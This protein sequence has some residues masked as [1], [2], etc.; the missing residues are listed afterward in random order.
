MFPYFGVFTHER[1]KNPSRD[2]LKEFFASGEIDIAH[3]VATCRR[4][5]GAFEPKSALEFGCGVGRLLI[6]LAKLTG[7]A[8]GVDVADGMLSLARSYADDAGASV[9]LAKTIPADE[10][11]DLVLS[12]ITLQ[13]IPPGRGYSLIAQLW[14]AVAPGGL[15]VL[16]VTAFRTRFNDLLIGS[17]LL[18]YDGTRAESYEETGDETPRILM[19]DYELSRVFACMPMA[20]GCP[21]YLEKTDHGGHHGFKI[22]ARKQS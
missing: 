22:Y 11:F 1:Y 3:F 18:N 15:I 7:H 12:H 21:L 16:H 14:G 4:V 17:S 6:P 8:T 20:D 5:F 10:K 9:I 13:H 19:Y 2:D